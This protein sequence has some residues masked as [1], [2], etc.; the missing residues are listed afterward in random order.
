[1]PEFESDF[2]SQLPK[3]GI[4]SNEPTEQI[5]DSLSPEDI[6]NILYEY[7]QQMPELAAMI[8]DGASDIEIK[9][10][11]RDELM[12]ARDE[13]NT[14]S[15]KYNTEVEIG[16]QWLFTLS[17]SADIP[18]EKMLT[19]IQKENKIIEWKKEE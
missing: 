15:K 3:S 9:M 13:A 19:R 1:M 8:P 4:E 7:W 14:D 16:T 17:A 2:E 5:F 10:I 11:I 12:Y 6:V 18:L